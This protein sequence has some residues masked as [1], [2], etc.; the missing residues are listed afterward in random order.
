MSKKRN[1]PPLEIERL[2]E[3]YAPAYLVSNIPASPNDPDNPPVPW[4]FNTYRRIPGMLQPVATPWPTNGAYVPQLDW[5]D[6]TTGVP[7]G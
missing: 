5:S 2:E 6:P 7:L 3:R 1:K 4:S